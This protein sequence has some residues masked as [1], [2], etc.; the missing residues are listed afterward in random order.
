VRPA[1]AHPEDFYIII[2]VVYS[3]ARGPV[4]IKGYLPAIGRV[5]GVR[6]LRRVLGEVYGIRAVSSTLR[7]HRGLGLLRYV[8]YGL[9]PTWRYVKYPTASILHRSCF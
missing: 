1:S 8:E 3:I 4:A 7:L 2:R 9:L 6:V 5:G